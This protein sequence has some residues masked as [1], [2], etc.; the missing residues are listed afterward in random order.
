[1]NFRSLP[2]LALALAAFALSGCKTHQASFIDPFADDLVNKPLPPGEFGLEKLDPKDYPD[3]KSA[4]GDRIN[5]EKAIDKSLQ[6]LNAKSSVMF[7]P[8]GPKDPITHDQVLAT[9]LDIKKML[10]DPAIT[11]DMFQQNVLTRYDVWA[12]RGYNW[13]TKPVGVPGDVWFTAYFTPIYHGSQ[14]PTSEYKYPVYS[15]PKDLASNLLTGDVY[16]REIGP[17][18]YTPYPTRRELT[19][20]NSAAL[21][22]LELCYFKDPMEPYIIQVQG[23][24][25]VILPD[26]SVLYLGYAGKNGRDYKG[27]GAQLLAAG[28][29]D[30]KHLSLPAVLEYFKQHPEERDEAIL[31]NDSF[32][33]LKVY[34]VKEWPSGSLGVQVTDNRS[35]AT[36]KK[37]FPRASLTFITVDRPA[38]DGQLLPYRG[39][40]LDQDTG[41]A[42]RAAGRADIYLG[43]G[44]EAGRQAG[45]QFSQGKLYYLFLK[46]EQV[47]QY[48][49]SFPA[50]T[51]AKTPPG[52]PAP[53]AGLPART[54]APTAPKTGSPDEMF[55]GAVKKN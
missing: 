1:M 19:A 47:Q 32:A 48:S 2:L 45:R 37:I 27:L 21:K 54:A 9:L 29:L 17:N 46:P 12:S 55:P 11:P 24:A 35:L 16:G 43:I 52:T 39:F 18:Q 51:P 36:D 31:N 3:M 7:Y 49:A 25:K 20:N 26:N 53:K 40:V 6:Y 38:A 42:I 41:G 34:D 50:L 44:D 13:D 33:F 30:A 15:R 14:T 22:G 23:S 5:L 4:W 10:H 8:S 28:K